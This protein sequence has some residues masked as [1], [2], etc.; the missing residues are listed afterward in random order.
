ME[1]GHDCMGVFLFAGAIRR[2]KRTSTDTLSV[3][4]TSEGQVK[5]SKAAASPK[6]AKSGPGTSPVLPLKKGGKPN[7]VCLVCC[8][9]C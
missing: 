8:S 7:L 5:T 3:T 2:S 6:L 4:S 9:S 1:T